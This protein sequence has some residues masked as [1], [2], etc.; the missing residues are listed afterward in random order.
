MEDFDNDGYVDLVYS[1]G[2]HAFFHNNGDNTFTEV[3]GTFP[4][5]DTMHSFAFGDVNR[6]GAV[7]LYASYGNGYVSADSNN[8]DILW[9]NAG[10]A[11]NWITFEL[12][13]IQSNQDAVGAKV[14][15]TGAF[16]TQIRE[17]RAGESYGITCTASCH[18]GL[19]ANEIVE[20]ATVL[21]PSGLETILETPAINQYHA[22]SEVS[23]VLDVDIASSAYGFCPGESVVITAPE[24]YDTYQW[25]NGATGV[26][27]ITVTDAGNYSILVTS[28]EGCAGSSNII[29]VVEILGQ[30]PTIEVEWKS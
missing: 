25:S 4:G 17:V 21:W 24:G 13:G 12:E 5:S 7:D 16:G 10:N 9:V 1:G 28:P 2:A 27:S 14:V 15:I 22:I 20:T 29:S 30:E 8:E 18:F 11:N 6:D 26:N 3:P 23:C 19:G